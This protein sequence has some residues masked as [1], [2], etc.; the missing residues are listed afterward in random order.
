[1][2]LGN[3]NRMSTR[4]LVLSSMHC[5]ECVV[6]A[7]PTRAW[8]LFNHSLVEEM[9]LTRSKTDS[10]AS[11]EKLHNPTGDNKVLFADV[12]SI[13]DFVRQ[14]KVDEELLRQLRNKLLLANGVLDDA[15]RQ[16]ITK[17]DVREWLEQLK[18]AI[19][20]AEDLVDDIK[21]EADHQR[22]SR[23]RKFFSSR[24]S[25]KDVERRIQNIIKSVNDIVEDMN[26]LGLREGVQTSIPFQIQR[27]SLNILAKESDV[28]GRAAE[29]QT[30]IKF[31]LSY[32]GHKF[33][34]MPLVGM[35]GIGKTTLAQLV[36][37][38][39]ID[40]K[41]VMEKPF[42]I[43]AWITVSDESKSD[44]FTL[45]KAIYEEV[46]LSSTDVKETFLL[47]HKLKEALQGKKFLFIL[48]NVWN[49]DQEI[50]DG[51]QTPFESAANGSKIIVTTRVSNIAKDLA[52]VD[53]QVLRLKSLT[54]ADCWLLFSKHAFNNV[55]PSSYPHLEEIGK[56][57]V[58]KCLGNPLAVK[59]L[60]CLLQSRLN[61]K[62]WE[63]VLTNDI[64]D[65][66]DLLPALWLSYYNLPPHLK[67]CFAYCS[68]F[69]KDFYFPKDRLI[70]LWMA[71]G[72]LQPQNN[73]TLEEVGE[74]YFEDLTSRSFFLV[75]GDNEFKMHDLMNDLATFVSGESCLRLDDNCSGNLTRRTR[76]IS[77][78]GH[79][80]RHHIAQKLERLSEN[81]VL[82][83][84]FVLDNWGQR[85]TQ[86]V[87]NPERLGSMQYLRVLSASQLFFSF[88]GRVKLLKSIGRLKHLRYLDLSYDKRIKEI[89]E[90][91]N[92]CNLQ[93]LLL[94]YCSS[95]DKLPESI[96]NLKHLRY[97]D[98]S[99]TQ[100]AN[101]PG[102]LGNLHEMRTLDLSYTQIGKIP[103]TLG[104]LHELR[105]LDLSWTPIKK[106][107]EPL[108]N[109]HKLR[110]LDLS[111]TPIEKISGTIFSLHELHT[112]Y[113]CNR[114]LQ[115]L[116]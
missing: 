78:V 89:P 111:H 41:V 8:N 91:C 14:I 10:F 105:T 15:E 76:H 104:N 86:H 61:T 67:R 98:L 1:M 22:G 85:A 23:V 68:I 107:P 26:R 93:T 80:M 34:V 64:W 99:W 108:G 7:N 90:I 32:G 69:P 42:V 88:G 48:D 101:I 31:L 3:W 59:S 87:I 16:Q 84:L 37:T 79:P 55:D 2:D 60:A 56:N 109:L 50:W 47:Q 25:V 33:S 17:P 71:Q 112:L 92:L 49:V 20:K 27:S 97:L 95:L 116:L 36:Y 35:G 102:T 66:N 115:W 83:T 51:I 29:K 12:H 19:Q 103:D 28:Y 6:Q 114:R 21:I 24:F 53:S 113:E 30:I 65:L 44:V 75:Y 110:T 38:D 39:V 9:H 81:N 5:S 62:E 52:T 63:D 45:T 57:I 72:L 100:I 96:G 74:Q 58:R 11:V 94:R 46:T 73:M 13:V 77:W 40:G 18:D 70:L 82:H 54:E 4:I 106:I 43:K